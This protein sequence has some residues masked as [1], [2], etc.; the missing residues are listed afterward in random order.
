MVIFAHYVIYDDSEIIWISCF[1]SDK[2][3]FS[4]ILIFIPYNL[5]ISR[6]VIQNVIAL[7]SRIR[8]VGRS[9]GS[10]VPESKMISL[11]EI[12]GRKTMPAFGAFPDLEG[13]ISPC[14]RATFYSSARLKQHLTHMS[15]AR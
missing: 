15:N 8:D 14:K 5:H 12:S 13:S 9:R 6:S 10:K 3:N 11:R 2:D 1:N 7:G 4:G